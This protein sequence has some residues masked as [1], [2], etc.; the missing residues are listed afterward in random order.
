MTRISTRSISL[1]M[2][3]ASALV[4]AAASAVAAT[5]TT[6][7]GETGRGAAGGVPRASLPRE[8]KAFPA[9]FDTGPVAAIGARITSTFGVAAQAA[10]SLGP[11][12]A[13]GGRP[14]V[15]IGNNPGRAPFRRFALAGHPS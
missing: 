1:A 13:R 8:I 5:I 11:G 12:I 14:A 10:V 4:P 7:P 9:A 15:G 3:L 2:G 6:E